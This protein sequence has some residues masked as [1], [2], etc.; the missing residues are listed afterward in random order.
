MRLNSKL[1]ITFAR[2]LGDDMYL[3]SRMALS[4]STMLTNIH[5]K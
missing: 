3:P 1:S 2:E 4:L 5:H